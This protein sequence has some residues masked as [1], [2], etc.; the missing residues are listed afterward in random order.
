[1]RLGISKSKNAVS[2]YVKEDYYVAGR[3]TSVIVE[4]LGNLEEIKE[5]TG[6]D[7]PYEWARQYIATLNQQKKV[8]SEEIIVKY[9]PD[10]TI[11]LGQMVRFNAGYLFLQSIYHELG[12][13]KWCRSVSRD[14]NFAFDLNAIL[15]RLLYT[16]ILY[17]G[18]K[19]ST[20]ELSEQFLQGRSFELQHVYR[21][22][23]VI[24]RE[25]DS[26]QLHLYKNSEM[27]VKR[28]TKIL[29]YDCTNFFFE[30]EQADGIK[31]YGYSKEH[32]PNPIVQ[33]GLFMDGNGIPLAFDIFP[34]NTNE[35]KTLT[36]L[37]SKITRDFGQSQFIVCTDAGL[38][39]YE[40]RR[41]N[42]I[43]QRAY[44]TTQSLK[45]LT[46]ERKEWALSPTGW[47]LSGSK[48]LYN[49]NEL[50]PKRHYY[51]TFYKMLP[52]EGKG[53]EEYLIVTFSLKYQNYHQTLRARQIERAQKLVASKTK[54]LKLSSQND[55]K[56]FIKRVS[57]TK[58][59]EVADHGY[60]YIDED[61][62][63][64]EAQFDGF[65]AVCTNL[66]DPKP[67]EVMRINQRRWEIEESFR[68]MKSEFK[69]RP[70]YLQRE[71]RIRAHFVTC[72]LALT[73]FRILEKR[74]RGKFTAHEIID[75]LRGMD[76]HE[77]H[78]VGFM[79]SYTRTDL[80]DALHDAFGFRT[81]YEVTTP[82]AMKAIF[83]MTQK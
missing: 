67:L 32:R 13:D 25:S 78:G 12:L 81:D 19:R 31:Q 53:V 14:K 8:E 65:Y 46:K 68:L 59:G 77:K 2:L 24:A 33:L 1:M 36:P 44:I 66:E 71:D 82:K 72:F 11:P 80:T 39:S 52:I 60:Y 70:V 15:S 7:D 56:R 20:H 69:S 54:S 50:D 83:K 79:P 6:T 73:V 22:L 47:I 61:V 21:A 51:K 3:K 16:R 5:R 74:L 64:N 49:L 17:P 58:D 9:K 34:G 4:R 41:F 57:T 63:S 23:E 55:C 75:T 43:G 62:I 27:V 30:I 26:L 45:K 18:S 48:K 35:Q 29:F 37:E 28:N 76:M 10:R 40:N 38:S 42:N